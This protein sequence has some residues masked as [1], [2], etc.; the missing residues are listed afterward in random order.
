MPISRVLSWIIIDLGIPLL[1]LSSYQPL[2]FE[3]A[4]LDAHIRGISAH[5]VY[6]A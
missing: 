3:R 1:A 6:P 2:S 4:V 5:K